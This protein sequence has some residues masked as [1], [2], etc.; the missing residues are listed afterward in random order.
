A[1]DFNGVATALRLVELNLHD[2]DMSLFK[3]SFAVTKVKP[4][5]PDELLGIPKAP[6]V[7]EPLMESSIPMTKGFSVMRR[8]VFDVNDAQIGGA[9]DRFEHRRHGRQ[10]AARK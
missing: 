9:A 10:A 4:P 7:V 5:K 3:E 2:A 8:Q 6:D 1:A